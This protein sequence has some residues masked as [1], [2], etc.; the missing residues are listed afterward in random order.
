MTLLFFAFIFISYDVILIFLNPGTFWDNVFS[1]TH[2]WSF[3]AFF[4]IIFGVFRIKNGY[5]IFKKLKR[6]QRLTTVSLFILLSFIIIGN[7][8]FIL[9]PK[10]TNFTEE[11]EQI[12]L[13]GGGIDKDGNLP[14]SVKT[15]VDAASEYLLLH[16]DVICVVTGGTLNWLP[17]PEAPAI[18]KALVSK[19][20]KEDKILIEDKA[21]DTIENLQLSCKVL[22]EF[23]DLPIQ[24]ILNSKTIIITSRFHL[25]RAE[26]IAKRIG[27]SK[28]NGI[29]AKCPLIYIPHNY[30]REICAYVKLNLRIIFTGQP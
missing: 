8:I 6:Y 22:S 15:R 30:L 3:F 7:L 1:F 24:D 19:G 2:I 13:L 25:R 20:I 27:F 23:R 26:R 12:I 17:Y 10:T 21:R 4:L 16:D 5:S 9:S 29:A 11:A 18:K 14:F 28:F